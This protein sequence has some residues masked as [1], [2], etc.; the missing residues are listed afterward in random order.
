MIPN[1]EIVDCSTL[2]EFWDFVSPIGDKF[3]KQASSYI[4]R[5]QGDS[6]WALTPRAY[7][8]EV[9]AR[10]KRGMMATLRDHPGQFF[11][12]WAQLSSFIRYCDSTG[13]A[14]PND[15]M[16]FRE[17]FSQS[18]IT[19]VHG[20]DS[21]DWPHERVMPLMALAQHHGIPTR[22]LDWS[23]HP[24]VA[25]YFAAA[26]VVGEMPDTA[27]KLAVF[28]L[29]M[30][31]ISHIAGI[32]HVRVPGST[33]ENLAGQGGSFIL[34]NN[35]GFRGEAFTPDVSLESKLTRTGSMLIKVTLP[36]P[37][38]GDLLLRCDKFGVSAASAFPGYGGAATAVLESTQALNFK[39]A[40]ASGIP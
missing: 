9:I 23:N 21:W 31:K 33:S 34:I 18:T 39:L 1:Y 11:F 29:D 37:L 13:L 17:Y 30:N 36:Q 16:E 22:L 6:A 20:I 28:G 3:G 40:A 4:F 25:C 7:R 15:S 19:H 5:G 14:L 8:N 27:K 26:S 32:K 35:T 24:Y 10:Y 12:E 2:D 38:A